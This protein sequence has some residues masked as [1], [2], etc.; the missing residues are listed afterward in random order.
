[1]SY[2]RAEKKTPDYQFRHFAVLKQYLELTA[3]SGK[4]EVGVS[5][6]ADLAQQKSGGYIWQCVIHNLLGLCRLSLMGTGLTRGQTEHTRHRTVWL[7]D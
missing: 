6:Q 1:M 2:D 7:F 3:S 4:A 5:A